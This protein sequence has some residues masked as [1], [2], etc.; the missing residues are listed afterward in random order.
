[1]SNDRMDPERER[2]AYESERKP[3]PKTPPPKRD[4]DR[5]R[6]LDVA[7]RF[8]LSPK[9][10]AERRRVVDVVVTARKANKPGPSAFVL[11]DGGAKS[12]ILRGLFPQGDA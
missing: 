7:E 12:S 2:L 10:I 6:R 4:V 9:P 3:V 8:G 5:E 11:R 1:M